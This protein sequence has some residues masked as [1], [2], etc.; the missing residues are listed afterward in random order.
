MSDTL[1]HQGNLSSLYLRSG[2]EKGTRLLIK[3]TGILEDTHP[4]NASILNEFEI[5]KDT[6]INGVRK[7]IDLEHGV[8]G[9]E[10]KLE[11]CEGQPINRAFRKIRGDLGTFLDIALK[12]TR[13]LEEVHFNNIIHRDISPGNILYDSDRGTV[14]LIDFG[15]SSKLNLKVQHLGNPKKL[16]GSLHY[17]SPEQSGRMDRVIDNRSDLY[18]L[19]VIFYELLSNRRPFEGDSALELVHAL[20]ASE[21]EPLTGQAL[22]ISDSLQTIPLVLDQIV[23]K[24]LQK[25]A[26]NRYQSAT[27]LRTDLK[28]CLDSFIETGTLREFN[29]ASKD[30]SRLFRIP[31][32][33]Y[34]MEEQIKLLS[35]LYK[36]A[37]LGRTSI[38]LLSGNS[39]VG[40][41][42]LAR[43]LHKLLGKVNG[44]F[45]SGKFDQLQKSTPHLALVEALS[46]LTN[47]LLTEE[48]DELE[49]WKEQILRSADGLG[50]V[51]TDLI[52]SLTNVIG[53]Q[54]EIPQLNTVDSQNRREYLL[55]NFLRCFINPGQPLL[56]FIDDLQW[57]DEASLELFRKL[58]VDKDLDGLLFI[59]AFRDNEV[60][61]SHPLSMTLKEI[62]EEIQIERIPIGPL[63]LTSV[64][65]LLSDTLRRDPSEINELS[66]LVFRKTAGNPFFVLQ[67]LKMVHES[68]GIFFDPK[69]HRW[70]WDISLIGALGITDNVVVLLTNKI[71]NLDTGIIDAL[72]IGSCIGNRFNLA[73]LSHL[74]SKNLNECLIILRDAIAEDLIFPLG[75][76]TWMLNV[77][78]AETAQKTEFEFRHDRIQQSVYQSIDEQDRKNIHLSIARQLI[79][80]LLNEDHDDSIYDICNHLNWGLD[81]ISDPEEKL[82]VAGYTATAGK[83]ARKSG[84]YN[85]ALNYLETGIK[86]LPNRAWIDHYEIWLSLY[87][88]AMESAFLCGDHMRM[89]QLMAPLMEHG[90]NILDIMSVYHVKVDAYTAQHDLPKA[91]AAGVEGL[92]KLSI[93]F[94]RK[95]GLIHVFRGLGSVKLKLVRK[96]VESLVELPRMTDPYMLEAMPLMERISPA[97]Y[98]SGSQLFPL[99]VFKMVE[100]SLK[101]GNSSLS[102]FS[103]ASFAITLSGVLGDYEGGYRFAELSM[104]L[105]DRFEDNTYKVKV[106]FVNYCFVRHWKEHSRDMVNPLMEAYRSGMQVGNLFS[107]TW[108]ACYAL[109]WKYFSAHNLLGLQ[110]ELNDFTRTFKRLKQDGAFNLADLLLRTTKRL[111]DPE[112]AS[113]DLSDE[114]LDEKDLLERCQAANDKTSIFFFYLNKMQLSYIFQNSHEAKAYADLASEHLEAV[115][116]LHYVPQFYFYDTLLRLEQEEVTIEDKKKIKTGLKKFKVWAKHA[117]MNFKHKYHLMRAEFECHLGNNEKA[118]VEYDKAIQLAHENRY[119]QEEAL[120][121]ERAYYFYRGLGVAHLSNSM[122]LAARQRWKEWGATAVL[123]Q[124]NDSVQMAETEAILTSNTSTNSSD[125]LDMASILKASN[126][127]SGE[128]ELNKLINRFMEVILE[129]SGADQGVLLLEKDGKWTVRA[130][131]NINE[132]NVQ[133]LNSEEVAT[134]SEQNVLPMTLIN[135]IIRSK[136]KVLLNDLDTNHQ[137]MKDPNL[138]D[139]PPKSLIGFPLI[140]KKK[141][142]GVLY[143]KNTLV[144]GAFNRQRLEILDIFGS[145][146]AISLE[147][148]RLYSETK[149]LNE[150]YERFVPKQFLSFLDKK[151]IT[152]VTV[153]DQVQ[154]EMTILFCDI[155]DFTSISENMSPQENFNFINAYL[156]IMEPNISDNGGF[157]DKFIGDAI[158]ALFPSDPDHAL[159]AA[160]AMINELQSFNAENDF[161]EIGNVRIGIGLHTGRMI[162]GTVGGKDRM[163]STV[164]SDAVNIASRVEGLTKHYGASLLIT[165]STLK[166]LTSPGNYDSRK[167]SEVIVKGKTEPIELYEVFSHNSYSLRQL[168]KKQLHSFSEAVKA[169]QNSEFDKG[170]KLLESICSE[171]PNDV[172]ASKFLDRCRNNKVKGWSGIDTPGK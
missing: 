16:E 57:A 144:K 169:Y 166:K 10:L 77:A 113:S 110:S 86:M 87:N 100:V 60:D 88:E 26:E 24:L 17:M 130:A 91:V 6:D 52:P 48:K 46:E 150:A 141:L 89:E 71:T 30:Y 161:S 92:A 31:E 145:Q 102:A 9:P 79:S 108:V 32:K 164:I 97:A 133:L 117:P 54:P 5:L 156:R 132:Q 22:M 61:S 149:A 128:I 70:S 126:L 20:I 73:L 69:K 39:G 38:V 158:M 55:S 81:L 159:D 15:A 44:M 76:Q 27:G 83:M 171:N 160:I 147:N 96:K 37:E 115:I 85:Q 106:F 58:L 19:G 152:Q 14:H 168:K 12:I 94:P 105:L 142:T 114:N 72:Q 125:L 123:N 4:G 67:F 98:M 131:A 153:G 136:E 139:D 148:A 34:G 41:S 140:N 119:Y 129:N 74:M 80:S 109:I 65:A 93:H 68:S 18:S 62:E 11:Y 40:K 135:Y 35:D 163:D 170:I 120:A 36:E 101:Y 49:I 172:A 103:Y 43:E 1:Y 104:R 162:L 29:I 66:N 118:R 23:L 45:I 42:A 124:M 134:N 51:L 13:I 121:C 47:I 50:K 56:I 25:N 75:N 111:T 157:I 151:S 90:R 78:S 59:G 138:R 84:A 167:I 3:K 143:L 127:L 122:L 107:G 155:R 146:V 7:V 8:D 21:P 28:A 33:L 112:K 154:K 99:L 95:P 53:F 137:F 82:A 116:G 64:E 63:E 165:G 2:P